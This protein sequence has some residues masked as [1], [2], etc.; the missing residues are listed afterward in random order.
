MAAQLILMNGLS[1]RELPSWSAVAISSLPVPLSPV[2][3]TVEGVSAT[4]SM[5][6]ETSCIWGD[7]PMIDGRAGLAVGRTERRA[8]SWVRVALAMTAAELGLVEG[9]GDVVERA[10]A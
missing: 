9:L 4:L 5:I 10:R 6:L 7:S 1:R 8:D 2:M 3:S